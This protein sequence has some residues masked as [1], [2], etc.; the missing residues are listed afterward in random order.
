MAF[1][2]QGPLTT[3]LIPSSDIPLTHSSPLKAH[4]PTFCQF[5]QAHS[6]LTSFCIYHSKSQIPFFLVIIWLVH[7]LHL[8]LYSN[9]VS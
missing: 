5:S 7:S 9:V 3:L 4:W 8:D 2:Q 6:D 1:P